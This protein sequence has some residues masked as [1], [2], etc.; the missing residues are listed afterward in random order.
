MASQSRPRF[1]WKIAFAIVGGMS[2]LSW[3]VDDIM[4]W[5]QR[6]ALVCGVVLI[7]YGMAAGAVPGVPPDAGVDVDHPLIS[8]RPRRPRDHRGSSRIMLLADV[9]NEKCTVHHGHRH[10]CGEERRS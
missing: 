7:A 8:A 4:T 2:F 9:H 5:L 6:A 10:R 3:A 1:M